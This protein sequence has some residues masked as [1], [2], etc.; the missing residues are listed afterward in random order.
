M[1]CVFLGYNRVPATGTRS[2]FG[3][4]TI[5]VAVGS[6]SQNRNSSYLPGYLLGGHNPSSQM[7]ITY[8]FV[9]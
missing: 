5:S 2:N 3:G 1:I 6:P 9:F 7:V 8:F 4:P